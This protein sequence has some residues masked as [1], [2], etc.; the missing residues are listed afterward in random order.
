ME[1]RLNQVKNLFYSQN[2]VTLHRYSRGARRLLNTERWHCVR[3]RRN[4]APEGSGSGSASHQNK[5]FLSVPSH[6][7]LSLF[8][9]SSISWQSAIFSALIALNKKKG[10][11]CAPKCFTC[12]FFHF[13]PPPSYPKQVRQWK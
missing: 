11:L 8:F 13:A 4:A 1:R 9:S 5:L 3:P 6:S 12:C 2:D 7:L 10:S